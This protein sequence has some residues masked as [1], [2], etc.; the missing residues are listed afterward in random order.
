M[1]NELAVLIEDQ[2]AVKGWSVIDLVRET[3]LD[4][5]AV[6]DLLGP[7]L[8]LAMPDGDV[9]RRLATGLGVPL[10]QV[11]L[12]AAEACGLATS[13]HGDRERERALRAASDEDLM[14]ELRRRLVAGR[15]SADVRRR[16]MSHLA[17]I[18]GAL[19]G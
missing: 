13:L 4:A 14:R 7:D 16:R 12:A 9:V 3:G 11:V 10:Q 19:T 1:A 2:M 5:G 8:L 15:N 18:Q 6:A 17:L